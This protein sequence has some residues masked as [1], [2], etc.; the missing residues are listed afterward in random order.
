MNKL[1][2]KLSLIVVLISFILTTQGCKKEVKETDQDK[3]VH[4]TAESTDWPKELD[5]VIA[6]SKNHKVL[7]ENDKVRVL[8]VTVLP[9][10]IEALHHHQWPSVLHFTETGD[11]IRRDGNGNVIADS[12][13]FKKKPVLPLTIWKEPQTAHYIENLSDSLSIKLI[14]VEL[15]Q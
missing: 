11:F 6:A 2:A 3:V 4:K 12:R 5:A 7:M 1:Y 9:N 10:E 8:E 14:R 13:K 15:K